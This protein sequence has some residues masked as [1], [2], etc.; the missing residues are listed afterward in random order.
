MHPRSLAFYGASNNILKMGSILMA[1][2]IASDFQGDIYPVH[3]REEQ[4]MNLQAYP[5]AQEIPD[6][7]DV[8]VLV[9]PTEVVPQAL[10][11]LGQAGIQRA[12]IISGGFEEI[13]GGEGRR[14][15]KRLVEVAQE[16]GI[17]FIGP[18]CIGIFSH[19]AS[20]NT[21]PFGNAPGGRGIAFASQSGAYTCQTYE[22]WRKM[23]AKINQT[24]S[25]GNEADLDLADCLEYLVDEDDVTSVCLYIESIRR[26]REFIRA[27][28]R[29]VEAKP[30]TAIYVGGT[31]AGARASFSHTAA[32]S[33]SE[34]LYDGILSQAGI[35]RAGDVEELFDI[36]WALA[37]LPPMKGDRVAV[38]TNSGGPGASMAY[39]C[40][41]AGLRV[42]AFSN[43][44][45]ERLQSMLPHTAYCVNPVDI[46]YALNLALLRDIAQLIFES[47]EADA[48]LIYGFF[49]KEFV[50]NLAKVFPDA[51][52]SFASVQ[53]DFFLNGV[54]EIALLPRQL[55]RPAAV[56]S[57]S[58][59]ES[60][61]NRIVMDNGMPVF[62]SA[63]RCAR[64]LVALYNRSKVTQ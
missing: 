15:Q 40:E 37:T 7:V 2:L 39:Q 42:P 45:R 22:L 21:T 11:D 60:E 50:S 38:I 3:L 1:N 51:I 36:T 48:A 64:A 28:R 10:E 30:V 4:V 62:S 5:R 32:I 63:Q 26:P 31:E 57:F 17:R 14:L 41:K 12:V 19:D 53:T 49:G 46:T 44:L 35:E 25:V 52:E 9:L 29:L 56:L 59:P 47:D 8:A 16:Y 24:I 6:A 13:P 18:N 61:P 33:G 23:G 20:L 55:G 34:E 43:A 58:G 54:K 27:A